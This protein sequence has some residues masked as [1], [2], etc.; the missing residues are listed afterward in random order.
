MRTA[1]AKRLLA[2][3]VWTPGPQNTPP[4]WRWIWRRAQSIIALPRG[5]LTLPNLLPYVT[6]RAVTGAPVV[7]PSGTF[8]NYATPAGTVD[9]QTIGRSLNFT[10]ANSERLLM[11]GITLGN[12]GAFTVVA[13][14]HTNIGTPVNTVYAEGHTTQ[15]DAT[16]AFRRVYIG[17][18]TTTGAVG[19]DERDDG[20]T[21]FS[22][23]TPS[24][25]VGNRDPH[26]IAW[27][28]RSKSDR[29]IW[30]DGRTR[31]SNTSTVGTFT[32][33][34]P[35]VGVRA[36]GSTPAYSDYLTAHIGF[37][38]ILDDALD[39]G[40]LARWYANP[41]GFLTRAQRPVLPR[42]VATHWAGSGTQD[43]AFTES[44]SGQIFEHVAA[45]GTDNM[46]TTAAGSATVRVVHTA[47]LASEAVAMVTLA[48]ATVREAP[49][50]APVADTRRT[51]RRTSAR[52]LGAH[53]NQTAG[54]LA[55]IIIT[56]ALPTLSA[57]S[58]SVQLEARGLDTQGHTVSLGAVIWSSDSPQVAT[59][60]DTGLV[61]GI[62]AGL[63]TIRA[64]SEGVDGST[65]VAVELGPAAVH[66]QGAGDNI[67]LLDVTAVYVNMPEGT[68]YA[69][70]GTQ[71]IAI[72]ETATAR[73]H[74]TAT[75][76]EAV[77]ATTT[78]AA[79]VRGT[80][81]GV[82]R[83]AAVEP[84]G[85]SLAPGATQQ[86]TALGWSATSEAL[87]VTAVNWS[88]SPTGRLTRVSVPGEPGNKATFRNA[89][90]GR[91][92]VTA[93]LMNGSTVSA[94]AVSRGIC[95][96]AYAD[97]VQL[98][99]ANLASWPTLITNNPSAQFYIR[100]GSYTKDAGFVTLAP[101]AG[102]AFFGEVVGGVRPLID[103]GWN[104]VARTSA[105]PASLTKA[106][107]TTA[108]DV[109]L[110]GLHVTRFHGT[111]YG[112][113][114]NN[115]QQG[116]AHIALGNRSGFYNCR[117]SEVSMVGFSVDVDGVV[118]GS[119]FYRCGQLGIKS[120]GNRNGGDGTAHNGIV[121]LNEISY[122]NYDVNGDHHYD[123]TDSAGGTKFVGSI[124]LIFRRNYAHNNWGPGVWFDIDNVRCRIE[125]NLIEDNY[126]SGAFYEISH[127]GI[128]RYNYIRGN[129]VA[130]NNLEM[131]RAGVWIKESSNCEVCYNTL[132]YNHH[133]LSYRYTAC[134]ANT[135]IG[136]NP[137]YLPDHGDGGPGCRFHHNTV[138]GSAAQ[139][140]GSGTERGK[141][142]G[143]FDIQTKTCN[144]GLPQT[145][146]WFWNEGRLLWSNNTYYLP[147][148]G[149]PYF[150]G[151]KSSAD[152]P[153]KT[154]DLSDLEWNDGA[155]SENEDIRPRGVYTPPDR[156]VWP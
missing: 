97:M 57:S 107:Q 59:V 118:Y 111:L 90:P 49:K 21:A 7:P 110:E 4:E 11:S 18:A 125:D 73:I 103:G 36:R 148:D 138:Y 45:T 86:F 145:P 94:T 93:Q 47:A 56:P 123:V 142:G 150:F 12:T 61:T 109:W 74:Q 9:T 87:S 29:Y 156:M 15:T 146:E 91:A 141:T 130:S 38:V 102:Q 62:S 133:E 132:V 41:Y 44:A 64:T 82:A 126:T 53:A 14:L 51:I 3:Q 13:Y 77:V 131:G 139:G 89:G 114:R 54:T 50:A 58:I 99:S 25:S 26:F 112:E 127:W 85:F 122:S 34:R 115:Q 40:Q 95:R 75:A 60:S 1:R 78:A 79:T 16:A 72:T 108:T 143:D 33:G 20:G 35:H 23:E 66:L 6:A 144:T 134:R 129:A 119:Q 135:L 67:L 98:T 83:T 5:G 65:V 76:S 101:T 81:A 100:A 128:I 10:R 124:G 43:L 39:V 92:T 69:G 37:L 17:S 120:D 48:S 42:F 84:E 88:T 55:S 80:G 147:A 137:I 31:A 96:K 22:F 155:W 152:A 113:S 28:C 68:H 116:Q 153:K 140:A 105:D 46:A 121:A 8:Q 2:P 136:N 30:A 104:G 27:V 63:A 106:F 52:V 19:W 149:K 32:M 71:A 24:I 151:Y 117:V 70:S 154:T